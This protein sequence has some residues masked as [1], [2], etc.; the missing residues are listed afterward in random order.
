MKIKEKYCEVYLFTNLF[1]FWCINSKKSNFIDRRRSNNKINR[2]SPDQINQYSLDKETSERSRTSNQ[3][4]SNYRGSNRFDRKSTSSSYKNQNSQSNLQIKVL[5]AREFL[6]LI[7]VIVMVI[8]IFVIT[9]IVYYNY[10][11]YYYDH[12]HF[13]YF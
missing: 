13:Y 1:F 8:V 9:T 12:C 10:Y 2:L 4:N 3:A 11:C 5:N 7:I 6:Y